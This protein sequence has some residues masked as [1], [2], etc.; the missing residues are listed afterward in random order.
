MQKVQRQVKAYVKQRMSGY[1]MKFL[2]CRSRPSAC[3][4][5]LDF[6]SLIRRTSDITERRLSMSIL[7]TLV[8]SN[9]WR[10]RSLLIFWR[11]HWWFM[12][13]QVYLCILNLSYKEYAVYPIYSRWRIYILP[14]RIFIGKQHGSSSGGFGFFIFSF[15]IIRLLSLLLR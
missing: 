14:C 5:M 10:R 9:K 15:F 3:E 12:I 4:F 8:L 7:I 2:R 6:P 1:G 13:V 11:F